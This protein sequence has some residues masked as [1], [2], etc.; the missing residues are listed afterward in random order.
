MPLGAQ[1]AQ[2][3]S[4]L[5]LLLLFLPLPLVLLARIIQFLWPL[6]SS[7]YASLSS[8]SIYVCVVLHI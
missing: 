6:I 1:F 8:A 4:D 2:F 3:L 7:T 5:V